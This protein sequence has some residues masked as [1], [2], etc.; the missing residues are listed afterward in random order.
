MRIA[1]REAVEHA[2]TT[3]TAHPLAISPQRINRW[4]LRDY[5]GRQL[6]F[7]ATGLKPWESEWWSA[8]QTHVELRNNITHKGARVA[9]EQSQASIEAMWYFVGFV[10]QPPRP[11]I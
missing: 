2:A 8:Y 6:Y 4:S 9:M 10:R 7:A 5:S 1:A 3:Q 11:P